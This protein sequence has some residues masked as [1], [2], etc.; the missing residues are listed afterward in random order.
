M[1]RPQLRY[2]HSPDLD[3]EN[4]MPEDPEGFSI[5]VQAMI[6]PHSGVGEE[7]FD[8]V[9]CS[10]TSLLSRVQ[11]EGYV[12]GRPFLILPEYNYKLIV[13]AVERL[14]GQIQGNSWET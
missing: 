11:T 9:V 4:S 2:L 8:F 13:Q 14:C 1:I 3:L 6:G 10:T 5:L 7:S 12:W